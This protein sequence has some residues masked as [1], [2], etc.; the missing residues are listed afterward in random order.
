MPLDLEHRRVRWFAVANVALIVVCAAGWLVVPP[1]RAPRV[2]VRWADAVDDA[3]REALERQ[4]Q[5]AAGARREG[6]TWSYDLADPSRATVGA[7][8]QHSAVEDTHDI[9]RL[10]ATPSFGAP[11]G[12]TMVSDSPLA[13]LRS[14]ALPGWLLR[15]STIALVLSAGWL[16][17]AGR[18]DAP[19][20]GAPSARGAP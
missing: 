16:W 13:R 15:F 4:F 5:L 14:S 6:Q 20:A 19:R 10:L 7:L 17:S 2:H 9:N 8:I 1:A 18:R 12:E 11:A 3:R